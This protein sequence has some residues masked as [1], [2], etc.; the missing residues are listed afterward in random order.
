MGPHRLILTIFLMVGIWSQAQ[1]VDT[2]KVYERDSLV[3]ITIERNDT[4]FGYHP[5]MTLYWMRVQKNRDVF[6]YDV[7]SGFVTPAFKMIVTTGNTLLNDLRCNGIK[8]DGS[9]CTR[10]V[11]YKVYYCW[12]HKT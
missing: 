9:R 12:Q 4:T 2:T 6:Y 10:A 7:K 5:D 8:T 11:K 3:S 1:T